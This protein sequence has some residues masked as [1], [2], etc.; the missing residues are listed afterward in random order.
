MFSKSQLSE[1]VLSGVIAPWFRA[2][3]REH[4]ARGSEICLHYCR[5]DHVIRSRTDQ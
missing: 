2:E 3:G 4:Q 1:G 5:A